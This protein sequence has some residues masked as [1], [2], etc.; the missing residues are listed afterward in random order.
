M[1]GSTTAMNASLTLRLQDRLSAGLGALKQR[2]DGIRASA[3]RI[4]AMGAI[5]SAFAVGAPIAQAAKFD[6]ILRSIAITAGKSGAEAETYIGQLRK[7]FQRLALDTA[8]SSEAV[9]NAAGLLIQRGLPSALIDKLLPV[10]A[11]VATGAGA[12]LSDV[13][14]VVENVNQAL[15]VTP[16]KLEKAMAILVGAAKEGKVE[17][18]DMAREF[19][20]LAAAANQ[21][22][23]KGLEGVTSLAGA[24]QV[25]AK[26]SATPAE[27]ANNLSNLFQ[28]LTRPETIKNFAKLGTD[29][30]KM[31]KQA[32]K[33]GLNP[34]EVSLQKVMD[35][36][37]GD[38]IKLGSLIGD[39]QAGR[40]LM[41]FL[42]D[43]GAEYL[44]I[45]RAAGDTSTQVLINDFL[46]RMDGPAAKLAIA[47][48]HLFQLS[49]RFGRELFGRTGAILRP[50]EKL[51][52]LIAY[53]DRLAP[54]LIGKVITWTA[55]ALALSATLGMVVTLLPFLLAGMK[56]LLS[57]VALLRTA[58]MA[59][60]TSLAAT[61]GM[62]GAV[63]ALGAPLLALFALIGA[64]AYTIWAN[65]DEFRGFFWN[66]YLGLRQVLSGFIL[67]L[68][69][70]FSADM[71]KIVEG[72]KFMWWGV[73]AVFSNIFE[74]MR[75]VMIKW[76]DDG[77]AWVATKVQAVADAFKKVWQDVKDWFVNL[78]SGLKWPTGPN[79]S[80]WSDKPSAISNDDV[81]S[82]WKR[83]FE[84]ARGYLVGPGAG[85]VA[86][87]PAEQKFKVEM[88][89]NA[90]PGV[91]R[92]IRSPEGWTVT[93]Q[94][95][96]AYAPSRGPV[97]PTGRP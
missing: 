35:L 16:D 85:D 55:A 59:L 63:V 23:L 93:P 17:L 69:G 95:L 88:W 37:K 51:G 60:W 14:G 83:R 1:S 76:I 64:A 49:E 66:M 29:F 42:R 31:L 84:A 3:E 87:A 97:S 13:A 6:D 94:L 40:A 47:T 41:P 10:A 79:L 33:E 43:F 19:P 71:G 25:A 92:D 12:A 80:T 61:S 24:I 9:A 7:Q 78:W 57:P 96:D 67:F 8:Q 45:K 74:V 53:V 20:S 77:L 91:V 5:G 38:P 32:E 4:G 2:L 15:G 34:L 11:K 82:V 50:L 86:R 36:T 81:A 68:D 73:S 75:L 54:S 48:E 62:W 52:D 56:V 21:F 39:L 18:R 58:F 44:R 89:L 26:A 22:G 65:W 90:P 30:H 27:A 28:S 70:V 46:T 72:L